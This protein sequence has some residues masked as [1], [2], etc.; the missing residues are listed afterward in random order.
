[1]RAIRVLSFSGN[2]RVVD[3]VMWCSRMRRYRR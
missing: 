2:F 3:A 1:M